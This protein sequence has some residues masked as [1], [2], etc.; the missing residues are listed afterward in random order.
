MALALSPARLRG[1]L[2]VLLL[3]LVIPSAV[4]V[5]QTQQQ[6][7]W[8][9]LH[10]A[11]TLAEELATRI[12]LQLQQRISLEE[13][14]SESD[15]Q[16]APPG[17]YPATNAAARS[18]LAQWPPPDAFPGLIG[19]FQVDAE[20]Q[21]S[22]PLLP[23]GSGDGAALALD[24]AEVLQ[25][26]AR[27]QQLLEVLSSNQLLTAARIPAAGGVLRDSKDRAQAGADPSSDRASSNQIE[28][29]EPLAS[30]AQ[31]QAAF[32]QIN[33]TETGNPRQRDAKLGRIDE[34]QL[35]RGY[36]DKGPSATSGSGAADQVQALS[37]AT[38]RGTRKEQRAVLD[39][40][41]QGE[42]SDQSQP[43][44]VR[45]FESEVD[46]FEFGLLQSGHGVLFRKVWHAGRRSIQGALLDQR[47][48]IDAAIARSFHGTTL[49]QMSDLVVAWQQDVLQVIPGE[50]PG[51][52]LSRASQVNGEL[53]YQT[54]LSAPL[55]QL[56]LIFSVR[57]LPAGPGARVVYWAS[58]VLLVVLLGGLGALY[59][60]GLRQ[61]LLARQQQDFV[62]AVSHELKTPLTSIRMYAEMLRAGWASEDKKASYYQY[63]Y[64]ESERLSRLIAN[65][66]QLARMERSDFALACKPMGAAE[67]LDLLRSKIHT[68]IE[69]AGFAVDYRIDASCHEAVV[70]VDADAWCQIMIN[71]V[72]NAIKYAK[73]APERRIE[74]ALAP[75]DSAA[76]L[77][78]S[79]RDFGPGV[80]R[81]QMGKIFQLFYRSGSELTRE[82]LGTGIGLALVRQLAR[83]MGGDVQ[84]CNRQP[85]AEFRLRLRRAR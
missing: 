40:D 42:L 50:Q 60:L 80:P 19:H 69:H 51:T 52:T 28:Q 3:A 6:L 12:D 71:L 26:Q 4:L 17:A 32:D 81:A 73:A 58:G 33:S 57:E 55:D 37:N 70:A 14:R 84:V 41:I 53:L 11:R 13:A 56:Q 83:A 74:I 47:E 10:Q 29:A 59:R 63:I 36:A 21:F 54:R 15:Y 7:R 43:G 61:L 62:S 39:S 1:F 31:S 25:R 48:L 68:Q 85:G 66:L 35:S 38:T 5:W 22:T 45:M 46:P 67:L 64:D 24:A 75:G 8:E 20:G 30:H 82:S 23:D 18:P 76:D 16:F 77:I 79:V 72:D 9:S 34:L 27:R 44:R 49:A 2:A 65:V 78:V